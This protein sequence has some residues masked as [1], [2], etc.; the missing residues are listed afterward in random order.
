MWIGIDNTRYTSFNRV[1]VRVSIAITNAS[2]SS[3][4]LES[5][6]F[7]HFFY[8]V[9]Y[10]YIYGYRVLPYVFQF[11]VSSV[12]IPLTRVCVRLYR[13]QVAALRR[14]PITRRGHGIVRS[15][16]HSRRIPLFRHRAFPLLASP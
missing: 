4:R 2:I 1:Y 15:L 3:F 10:S 5:S 7:L 14:Y 12:Y 16:V 8:V 11:V 13:Q 6:L 9:P